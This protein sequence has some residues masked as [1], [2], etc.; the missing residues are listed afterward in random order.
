M[1]L[2]LAESGLETY[3]C[4]ALHHENKFRALLSSPHKKEKCGFQSNGFYS[5]TLPV[6]ALPLASI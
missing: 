2:H 3:I 4:S 1:Y 6:L 5:V